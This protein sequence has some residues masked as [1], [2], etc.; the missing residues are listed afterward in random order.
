MTKRIKER[1]GKG[2]GQERDK[3]EIQKYVTKILKKGA[4]THKW[5][6]GEKNNWEWED[7]E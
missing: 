7:L 6:K 3:H 4:G 5:L 1:N 2:V